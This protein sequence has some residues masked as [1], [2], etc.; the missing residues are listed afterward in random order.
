MLSSLE[1]NLYFRITQ[2]FRSMNVSIIGGGIVGLSTAFWLN[3]QGVNVT[4]IERG[5]GKHGCSFGNAGYIS[6]SHFIPLA[7]PGIIAQGIK[8][9]TS[10]TSPFYI[11][12]RFNGDLIKWSY[13]FWR[14]ANEA[15][16][17]KHI[18]HLN[19]ILQHSREKTIEMSDLMKN[20]FD[21][22]LKGCT[23]MYRSPKTARHEEELAH[24]A[25]KFGLRTEILNLDELKKFEPNVE[26][27]ALGGVWYE[28]DAHVN[29]MKMMASLQEYLKERNV[30]FHYQTEVVDFEK[31]GERVNAC[32]TEKGDKIEF[33]QLVIATGSWLP[34]VTKKLG[35]ALLLQP[36]K[37]YSYT[38]EDVPNNLIHPA[39]LVDDRVALTPLGSN[40]RT[41]G[42]MELSGLNHH[43]RRPRMDAI[44]NAAN[45]S[46]T[47]L[48]LA[49]K[50]ESKIWCG[51]RPVTPDGL[52]YLG[53]IEHL[54]NVCIA[55]G[56]AMLGLS[57]A[58]GAGALISQ[59]ICG[60][61][62]EVEL[63]A[64]SPYRF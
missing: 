55:G 37:G 32:V 3:Q 45:R 19:A 17:R 18:P 27:N 42:T 1:T 36:G 25:K 10:S 48:N 28:I 6:P 16:M 51:L 13:H 26:V 62:T 49:I 56:H 2:D 38:F 23:M 53:R 11:K 30:V 58:A 9:M 4:V 34:N 31:S 14:S 47:N 39:I 15:T 44:V 7:S 46:F 63:G 24:E 50:D 60:E 40:L 61:K 64:F 8:W 33:D 54:K 12:P 57:L 52:P 22:E 59:L 20:P 41:G 43:I 5:D 21:L 35:L 29:P